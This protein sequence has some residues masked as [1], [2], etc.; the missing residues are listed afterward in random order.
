[1]LVPLIPWM[2][3][4]KPPTVPNAMK[5]DGVWV[6]WKLLAVARVCARHLALL[7]RGSIT[8]TGSSI[9]VRASMH[10]NRSRDV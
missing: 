8:L 5:G 2:N 4:S 3:G 1:M 6:W 9:R 10:Y 7:V